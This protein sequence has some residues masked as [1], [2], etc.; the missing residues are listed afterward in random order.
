[1]MSFR[2]F[3][4]DIQLLEVT[5]LKP[6]FVGSVTPSSHVT[7]RHLLSDPT[8]LPHALFSSLYP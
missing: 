5:S 3:L 8:A 4:A 2:H 6:H 7:P 1:M